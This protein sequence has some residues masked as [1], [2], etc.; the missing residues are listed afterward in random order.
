MAGRA[1]RAQ[2]LELAQPLRAAG[3][4]VDCDVAWDFPPA[5]AIVRRVLAAKPDLVVAESHRHSRIARWFLANA[6]W[7]LIR[8]CPCPV[9]FV[10]NERLSRRPLVLAAVDPTHAHAK[11][12]G[13]DDR[14]LQ[15]ANAVSEQLGGRTALIHVEDATQA[16]PPVYLPALPPGAGRPAAAVQAATRTAISRLGRRHGVPVALQAVQAGAP[17]EVIARTTTAQKAEVLVMGA[18][19]RS[20]LHQA[21]IGNTAEAVSDEVACAVLIVKPRGFKTAV[22]RKAPRL[23]RA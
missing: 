6:D 17:A 9:W 10:K 3:L 15:T 18:V 7:D 5:Q 13:L 22:R 8:E 1:R 2:L 21:F 4:K 14:L 11:P 19:S 16:G 23:P 20:G 12:S